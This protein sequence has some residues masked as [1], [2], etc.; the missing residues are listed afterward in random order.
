M[1]NI[2]YRSASLRKAREPKLPTLLL[3][4]C[5]I[6]YNDQTGDP[7]IEIGTDADAGFSNSMYPTKRHMILFRNP[8]IVFGKNQGTKVCQQNNGVSRTVLTSYL[9][10]TGCGSRVPGCL[11]SQRRGQADSVLNPFVITVHWT[12]NGYSVMC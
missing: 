11:A 3:Y 1:Q 10:N 7:H 4:F 12:R 9:E 8:V 2:L 6:L 5:T